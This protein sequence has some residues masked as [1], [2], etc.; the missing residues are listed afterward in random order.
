V[1]I[2][3]RR[4]IRRLGRPTDHGEE[5]SVEPPPSPIRLITSAG[6]DYR[7]ASNFDEDEPVQRL[8]DVV[9]SYTARRLK[10]KR[11]R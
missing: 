7:T 8:G 1:V 3:G 5:P 11:V 6:G 4:R 10:P 9:G 2:A